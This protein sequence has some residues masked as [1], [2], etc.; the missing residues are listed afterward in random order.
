MKPKIIADL[1]HRRFHVPSF[2]FLFTEPGRLYARPPEDDEQ[3]EQ[4]DFQLLVSTAAAHGYALRKP[5][6][7]GAMDYVFVDRTLCWHTDSKVGLQVITLLDNEEPAGSEK[8]PQLVTRHGGIKMYPGQMVAFDTR[9]GH[10]WLSN[11]LS[12]FASFTVSRRV[13][14]PEP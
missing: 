9:E 14:K 12:T 6:H 11:G 13:V 2:P 1:S 4:R 10:A 7:C 5:R 8:L 3:E